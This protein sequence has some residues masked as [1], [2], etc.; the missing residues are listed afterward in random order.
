MTQERTMAAPSFAKEILPLFD[1][2]TDIPHMAK[3]GVML[4]D[5]A[6]MSDAANAQDVLG[7]L[8]GA[9]GRLMPPAPAKP[10]PPT[11]IALFKAWIDGGYQP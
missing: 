3:F 8:T 7:R 5:Y 11:R 1:P 10:W 6:Y 9:G 4:A 2:A